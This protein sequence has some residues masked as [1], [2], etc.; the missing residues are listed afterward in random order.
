MGEAICPTMAGLQDA[1]SS[2]GTL[3]QSATAGQPDT[4]STAPPAP[5]GPV[6]GRNPHVVHS[7]RP[8]TGQL[9]ESLDSA[10]SNLLGVSPPELESNAPTLNLY[11]V[12]S[13]F[14]VRPLRGGW[15]RVVLSVFAV[16]ILKVSSA[17]AVRANSPS[18]LTGA[19]LS[20]SGSGAPPPYYP[21]LTN[22][23]AW[24]LPTA[25][26]NLSGNLSLPQVA[27]V[28]IGSTFVFVLAF[29]TVV[30][31]EGTIL[32]FDT[33]SYAPASALALA[34]AGGCTGA[35]CGE[36]LPINWN[37]P[38]PIAAYG[39]SPIQS[40]AMAVT[41][42]GEIVVA[43]ASNSTTRVYESQS[44]GAA[45]TWFA[46]SGES[47]IPGGTPE[48]AVT[49][50]GCD[51]VVTTHPEGKTQVWNAA[52]TYLNHLA[53]EAAAIGAK[54]VARVAGAIILVGDLIVQALEQLLLFLKGVIIALLQPIV[55][56][57]ETELSSFAS[58][59][60]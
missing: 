3:V 20:G 34:E 4:T 2:S 51:V 52:F 32:E 37:P 5:P 6:E 49:Q 16:L 1:T 31:S 8:A 23:S 26:Q 55:T 45:A 39:G 22:S 24:P 27:T 17:G 18:A 41:P 30:P 58:G 47:P 60:S 43:A 38:T 46:L 13:R 12:S 15:I 59:V 33:G 25:L 21:Y 48:V 42:S 10:T 56:A 11:H 53:H 9:S 29:V 40:D 36:H 28:D 7:A 57:M 44:L 35:G 50:A 14:A 54:V 19:S